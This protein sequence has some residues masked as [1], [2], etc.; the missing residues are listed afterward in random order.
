MDGE[1]RDEFKKRVAEF[2]DGWF[3]S[4]PDETLDGLAEIGEFG[5]AFELR[6][7]PYGNSY[8][9]TTSS[10]TRPWVQA[11]L[12]RR[13][14]LIHERLYDEGEPEDDERDPGE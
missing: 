9:A 12:F 7:A 4:A 5:L 13:A 8:I 14:M 2:I 10:E 6:Y 1:L 11:A 3:A